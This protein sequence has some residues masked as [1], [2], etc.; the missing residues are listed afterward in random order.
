M[1]PTLSGPNKWPELVPRDSRTDQ[2]V[3]LFLFMSLIGWSWFGWSPMGAAFKFGP[4]PAFAER[5]GQS[6]ASIVLPPSVLERTG[7]AGLRTY[8]WDFSRQADRDFDRWPDDFER[9]KATGFPEYVAMDIRPRDSRLEAEILQFDTTMVL[10]WPTIRNLLKSVPMLPELPPLPPS[11]ADFMVD[12]CLEV[13]LDGGQASIVTPQLPTSSTYQYRFSVDIK[14]ERLVHDRVFAEIHFADASGKPLRSVRTPVVTQTRGW[15]TVSIDKMLPPVGAVSMKVQLNV[16][17]S[18]D[19]LEDIRGKIAFDNILFQ[20]FPQMKIATDRPFGVY[21]TGDA[22]STTTFLLGL[23][24]ETAD[25]RLRL[26]DHDGNEMRTARRQLVPVSPPKNSVSFAWELSDLSPGFYRITAAMENEDGVSLAN[27]SSFVVIDRLTND[28]RE[29][30][31]AN[32]PDLSFIGNAPIDTSSSIVGLPNDPLPFGW[33]LPASLLRKIDDGELHEKVIANWLRDIGVGWAKLPAWLPPHATDSADAIA[34]LALRL[35]DSGIEPVGLLDAPPGERIEHY[36]LRE[37]GETGAAAYFHDPGIWKGELETIMNRMTIRIKR[38]QLGRDDDFS[39]QDRADLAVKIS[40]IG[41]QLQGFGQP[42][43]IAVPWQWMDFPPEVTGESWKSVHRGVRQSLT[44]DELDAMLDQEAL[45]QPRQSGER[46]M[47]LDPLPKDRYDLDGRITD[48]ILRMATIRGHDVDAAF[49]TEPL[50]PGYSLVAADGHPEE[51]LL[52]WRTASLLLGRT[53]NIGSLRLRHESM[54]IVF[55][56]PHFSLLLIWANTPRTERLFLGDNA[57]QID[58]WGRRTEIATEQVGDLSVQRIEVDPLPKFIVGIDPALAE[59]RMSVTV[60]Q[61]R[62]DAIL[63]REQPV[64]V[65]YFNPIGQPLSGTIELKS[66]SQWRVAPSSQPWGLDP[67]QASASSFSV[68]LGNDATIGQFELPID[69]TFA[70]N[71][72]TVIRVYRR[73]DVGPEGFELTVTTRLID[74]RLNVKIQMINKTDRAANFDCL[75][76]AG[77][78]RQYE[79]RV[80][81]LPPGGTVERNVVWSNGGELVGKQLL[82]RAIEQDGDRVINHTFK[83]T[84]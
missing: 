65:R 12:R 68:T 8:R 61:E 29:W 9:L 82:L 19:G 50:D 14:T 54:N 58:V 25:I 20:Q 83:V 72:P 52:P 67:N 49:A 84:P 21:R 18:E 56:G 6:R 22:V 36:R 51:L 15:Q 80:L 39:F 13:R 3:V 42:L 81:V 40:E 31:P 1:F 34:N 78:D 2:R 27:E 71:P 59:F 75:L 53:R 32:Q 45:E 47:S 43:E 28:P 26:L 79:R 4:P 46:W 38:W 41:R 48:L 62:I 64:T 57:Y 74:D 63:G 73:L 77:A 69:F 30:S 7:P 10:Q 35:Q 23:P 17:G 33:S 37:R 55:R 16:L 44:A 66:P 60:D 5:S 24:E 11:L 70:T 76:F